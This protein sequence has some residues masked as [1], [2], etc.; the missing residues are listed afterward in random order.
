MRVVV[1][2][3]LV[4]RYAA[5][6]PL[7]DGSM[8]DNMLPC[9]TTTLSDE[10]KSKQCWANELNGRRDALLSLSDEDLCAA[11]GCCPKDLTG[12][13]SPPA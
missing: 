12:M 6:Q 11:A 1:A 3:G 4:T 9:E 2:V 13:E 5:L 8:W 7:Q 10:S